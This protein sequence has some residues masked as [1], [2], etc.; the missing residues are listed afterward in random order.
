MGIKFRFFGKPSAS[1]LD[2][3]T[4]AEVELVQRV[5]E[6]RESGGPAVGADDPKV[7]RRY[8]FRGMVQGVGFR[9]TMCSLAESFGATGWVRNEADGSVT[10][11]VQGNA[12]QVAATINGLTRH[13]E[14]RSWYGGFTIADVEDRDPIAGERG[15]RA[16]Y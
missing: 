11:E 9:F 8:E 6:A 10:A 13:F 15:F 5:K 1:D 16:I 12:E 3:M 2:D 14:G 7:R 4:A